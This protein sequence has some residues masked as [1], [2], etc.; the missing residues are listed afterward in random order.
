MPFSTRHGKERKLLYV[1]GKITVSVSPG[2]KE[3]IIS[4]LYTKVL[5][6]DKLK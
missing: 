6:V 4:T 2:Q 1:A 3:E 5:V